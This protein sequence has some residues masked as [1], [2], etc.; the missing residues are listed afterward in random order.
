MSGGKAAMTQRRWVRWVC[1]HD[2]SRAATLSA[3]ALACLQLEI[4]RLEA[5]ES[6]FVEGDEHSC[7]AE[8]IG[9]GSS[10]GERAAGNQASSPGRP[11]IWLQRLWAAA[12]ALFTLRGKRTPPP[13]CE[14]GQR[15]GPIPRKSVHSDI[16]P[17]RDGKKKKKK[18]PLLHIGHGGGW[19]ASMSHS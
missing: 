5:R 4:N 1:S 12:E 19:R 16:L 18:N 11:N 8:N 13:P 7:G 9:D 3:A 2:R 14:G 10:R 6:V 15:S 17:R